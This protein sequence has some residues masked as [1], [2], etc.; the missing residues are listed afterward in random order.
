MKITLLTGKTF[1]IAKRVGFP[2]K[3]MH[4]ARA[5]RMSLRIDGKLRLPVLTVPHFCNAAGAV[6]F[7]QNNRQWIENRLSQLAVGRPFA[8]GDVISL[9]GQKVMICHAHE[10]RSGVLWQEDK[11]FV[12][13]GEEFLSRRVKDFIYEEAERRLLRMSREKAK[14]IACRV[15]RVCIKDTKS[16]WGSCSSLNNINYNWRIA[17]APEE[18]IDYLVA[19]E[20][21]HLRHRDH[22]AEFWQCVDS[23]SAN[24]AAGKNWLR[25]KGRSLYIYA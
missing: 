18:A 8:N 16:R 12:S 14:L 11:L 5:K 4:S 3:V 15:N 21:S 22:S 20:V 13:G 9:F 23:L 10:Q 24:A 7:V 6:A 19:H 2:I 25:Q 1:D 17:L